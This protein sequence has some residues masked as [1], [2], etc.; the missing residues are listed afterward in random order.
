MTPRR[1]RLLTALAV[2]IYLALALYLS[3]ILLPSDDEESYLGLGRLAV[4]G[5]I[6]LFEDGL[7]GQ[8]M[9]LPFYVLEQ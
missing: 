9:P 2:L 6:S 5:A 8:R 7:T 1:R 3:R 4:T